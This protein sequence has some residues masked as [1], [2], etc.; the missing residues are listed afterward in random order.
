M[1]ELLRP[2][3]T[4]APPRRATFLREERIGARNTR[5]RIC[6]RGCEHGRRA[7]QLTRKQAEDWPW[8]VEVLWVWS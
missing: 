8:R 1:D 3:L 2:P 4:D 6:G 5:P 7:I